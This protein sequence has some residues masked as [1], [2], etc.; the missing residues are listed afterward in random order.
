M[1]LLQQIIELLSRPPGSIIYHL[2][3]LFALQI[4]LALA[5]A[6]WQRDPNDESARRMTFAAGGILVARLVLLFAGLMV[7]GD[8][9]RARIVLPPL[10]QAIDL[11]TILLLVWGLTP[12]AMD[13]P[14]LADGVLLVSLVVVAVMF[15]FFFQD[16][17][18]RVLA[19]GVATPYVGTI[20]A[21]VW[22]VLQMAI[23]AAGLVWLAL[24]RGTRLTLRPIIVAVAL[25]AHV[26]N[27]FNYPEI[28]PSGTEVV[29]WLR[30]GYLVAFPLWAVQAYRDNMRDL[31]TAA[32]ADRA[33]A[34]QMARNLRLATGVI[35]AH[36]PEVRLEQALDMVTGLVATRFA[37]IGL[38]DEKN[39][40]RVVFGQVRPAAGRDTSYSRPINLSDHAAFRLAYEQQRGIELLPRGVGARQAHELAQQF[41]VGPLGPVF[42]E[43]LVAANHCFGFLL[44]AAPPTVQAWS[45]RDRAVIPGVASFISQAIANSR[46]LEMGDPRAAVSPVVSPPR[47]P[48]R[49]AEKERLMLELA[50]TRRMLST[51]EDRARQAETA[52][53]FMQQREPGRPTA[54]RPL[55]AQA[56]LG[57]AVDQAVSAVLPMLR[58]KN[59]KLDVAVG[60]ELPL[61]AVRET[62][63]R[64]LALSLLENACR[65]STQDGRLL[66]RA[67]TVSANG[68]GPS[69]ARAVALIVSDAGVGIRAEDRERV[70]DSQYYLGGGRP[71]VGLGDNSANLA[72][73][74]KLAQAS[75]GDLYFESRA[76]AGT[77]FTLRLPAA[78]VRPWTMLKLKQE[79]DT[80][81]Q[82]PLKPATG[83]AS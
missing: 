79:R 75:G 70:F 36:I 56:A 41:N 69:T 29:Y 40:Q 1:A 50:D 37:A 47:A 67:E 60:E 23:L 66:V 14:R 13:R 30:L 68:S 48:E 46:R 74:Q 64:Q 72:V 42:V 25:L 4:V 59:L 11:A 80:T 61:A 34:S 15:L 76:G 18:N 2:L 49:D 12:F 6:R 71:I 63:L 32:E 9:A 45:D 58:Q 16:W 27:F 7:E 22:G 26:A 5:F 8:P 21:Y 77:T 55:V 81:A 54:A 28:I 33:Q 19:G 35:T 38:I 52:A 39:P 44:L 31:L 43:P 82:E 24:G 73:V 20:Q 3:T 53:V 57:P 83:E 17:Q 62:V 78:E 51:A 10:E 65:A